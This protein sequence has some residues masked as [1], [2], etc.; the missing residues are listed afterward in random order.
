MSSNPHQAPQTVDVKEEGGALVGGYGAG[1]GGSV[2]PL[3]IACGYIDELFKDG[4]GSAYSPP[5]GMAGNHP[6]PVQ[7]AP[8][9]YMGGLSALPTKP[10]QDAAAP[11]DLTYNINVFEQEG[12]GDT[13]GAGRGGMGTSFT[14]VETNESYNLLTLGA[15]DFPLG[16]MDRK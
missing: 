5:M 7:T 4:T 15:H 3:H 13:L 11:L 14:T 9:A 6:H 1:V 12:L 8:W 10:H 2:P 16:D